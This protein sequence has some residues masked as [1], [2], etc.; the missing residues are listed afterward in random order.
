MTR[1]DLLVADVN[2]RRRGQARQARNEGCRLIDTLGLQAQ[3]F[4]TRL[5]PEAEALGFREVVGGNVDARGNCVRCQ[6]SSVAPS[7]GPA[8]GRG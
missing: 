7:V 6:G 1:A 8:A 3:R 2:E 5:P 4:A